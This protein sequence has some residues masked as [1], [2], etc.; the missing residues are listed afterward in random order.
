VEIVKDEV[1]EGSVVVDW[2]TMD[3]ERPL[4]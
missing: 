3:P 2:N 1:P 4:D